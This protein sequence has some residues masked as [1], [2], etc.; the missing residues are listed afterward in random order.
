[1]K[2]GKSY[3]E[4]IKELLEKKSNKELL[5]GFFGKGGVDSKK[6]KELSA[7]WKKWSDEYA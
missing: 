6:V 3:S 4:V 2:G 5:L 7:S 1:M